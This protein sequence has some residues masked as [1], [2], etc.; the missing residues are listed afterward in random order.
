LTNTQ[1]QMFGELQWKILFIQNW[2]VI[3]VYYQIQMH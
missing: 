3:W 1:F 2:P